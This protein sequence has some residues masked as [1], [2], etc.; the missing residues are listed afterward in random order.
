MEEIPRAVD[1]IATGQREADEKRQ[2][3]AEQ[4]QPAAASVGLRQDESITVA[5]SERSKS[6]EF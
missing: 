6:L 2:I 1:G 5:R 3:G 4:E